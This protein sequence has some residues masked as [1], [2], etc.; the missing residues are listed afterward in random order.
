MEYIFIFIYLRI[1]SNE[2]FLNFSL[3]SLF[4][5]TA[6]ETDKNRIEKEINEY[7]NSKNI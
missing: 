4:V 6:I 5:R 3:K 7:I 2:L 1:L